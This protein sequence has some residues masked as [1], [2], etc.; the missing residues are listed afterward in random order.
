MAVRFDR[1]AIA[2]AIVLCGFG[3]AAILFRLARLVQLVGEA[4]DD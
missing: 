2:P 4:Q 1:Q 3:L